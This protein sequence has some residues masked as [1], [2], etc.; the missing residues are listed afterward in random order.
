ML[1]SGLFS[2]WAT[3]ATS[4]PIAESF[5]G[6]NQLLLQPP[7]LGQVARDAVN[8]LGSATIVDQPR[9][10]FQQHAFI[11]VSAQLKLERLHRPTHQQI[12]EAWLGFVPRVGGGDLAQQA[13]AQLLFGVAGQRAA[14]LVDAQDAQLAIQREDQVVG[15]CEQIAVALLAALDLLIQPR[16]VDRNRG[17]VG[18]CRKQI[19]DRFPLKVRSAC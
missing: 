14:D 5:S 11:I 2:S 12:G 18:Q 6:M 10:D 1:V 8:A 4:W 7:T 15:I 16:V 17:V 19:T 3:P 13:A 9:A